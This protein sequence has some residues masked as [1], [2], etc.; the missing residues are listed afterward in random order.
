VTFTE[1][2][3]TVEKAVDGYYI[4]LEEGEYVTRAK[5]PTEFV[6][7]EIAHRWNA[8]PALLEACEGLLA[9]VTGPVMVH[10]DGRGRDG[11]KDGL[12][13]DEFRALRDARID[14]ARAALAQARAKGGE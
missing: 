2:F 14:A 7:S 3:A 11:V 5:A 13:G 9:Q 6:A 10:G 12:S 1:S 8:Y 4:R